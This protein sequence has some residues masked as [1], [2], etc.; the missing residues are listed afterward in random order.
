MYDPAL[1]R[2]MSIDP[3][4]ED[5]AMQSPY[6]YAANNPVRYTEYNGMN[7]ED[8]VEEEEP[9]IEITE[10]TRNATNEVNSITYD[11][12]TGSYT[13][14]ETTTVTTTVKGKSENSDGTVTTYTGT[15]TQ[16]TNS[17]TV[18]NSDGDITS[19]AFINY[20]I[21]LKISPPFCI[22]I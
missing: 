17:T 18:V 13:V 16:T 15:Q 9:Q 4:A 1:G 2:F 19:R 7:P 12:K 14:S 8:K 10:V 3:L 5:Y 11:K 20:H 22:S 6:V 21:K